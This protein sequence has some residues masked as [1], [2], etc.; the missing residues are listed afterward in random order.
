MKNFLST[1][2]LCLFLVGLLLMLRRSF[3]F[4]FW[5][6]LGAAALPVALLASGCREHDERIQTLEKRIQD[7]EAHTIHIEEKEN[8]Q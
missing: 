4:R 7:M 1:S 8:D 6:V 5:I 3:G 2:V